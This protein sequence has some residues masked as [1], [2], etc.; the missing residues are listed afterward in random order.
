METKGCDARVQSWL[1]G[2]AG[3]EQHQQQSSSSSRA[4]AAAAP[5]Y[6]LIQVK[7]GV[8]LLVSYHAYVRGSK[9]QRLKVRHLEGG[10]RGA[11]LRKSALIEQDNGRRYSATLWLSKRTGLQ[12]LGK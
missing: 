9:K 5:A 8:V 3:A 2:A 10:Q 12:V 6:V 7:R 4:A 11:M 1:S